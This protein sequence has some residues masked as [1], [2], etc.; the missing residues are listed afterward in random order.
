METIQ[1]PEA[2]AD[3]DAVSRTTLGLH[4][5]EALETSKKPL[6]PR[7]THI[8]DGLNLA[9]HFFTI[10]LVMKKK[11]RTRLYYPSNMFCQ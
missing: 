2:I 4:F 10:S 7:W 3:H 1:L 6:S 11:Q 9:V 8:L 5:I